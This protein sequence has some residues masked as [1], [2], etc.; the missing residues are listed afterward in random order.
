MAVPPTSSSP[1][2]IAAH[3]DKPALRNT[4]RAARADHVA[5]LGN[6]GAR[7]AAEAAASIVLPHIPPTAIVALYL[8]IHDEL[9]PD[10]LLQVLAGRRQPLALPAL[11]DSTAM[12]FRSW[13]PGD[14][15]ERG[16]F[17]L[18]QPL[19][20]APLVA[21]DLIVTPLLGFDRH[22]GRI[23][24]GK[25]HYDRALIRFPGAHRIGFAWSIQEV[26]GRL[27]HDPWD[28]PLHAIVTERAFIAMPDTAA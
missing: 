5:R 8:A 19:A 27:P 3:P 21:P 12:D 20:S 22:G 9:D 7:A 10:P 14:P 4:L 28:I 6:E 18:R 13:A 1:E 25:S 11:Y 24:Q 23:G 2:R 15:I 17:R 26:A 16:P